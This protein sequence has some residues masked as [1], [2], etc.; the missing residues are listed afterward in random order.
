MANI[1]FDTRKMTRFDPARQIFKI[2]VSPLKWGPS[3]ARYKIERLELLGITMTIKFKFI[4]IS[5]IS[6][7][8]NSVNSDV[9]KLGSKNCIFSSLSYLFPI[10]GVDY[11]K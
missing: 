3:K 11:K 8:T 5:L 4:S 2:T 10:L 6:F 1:T 9:M 7:I